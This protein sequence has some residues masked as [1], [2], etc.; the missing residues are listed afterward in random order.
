MEVASR[1]HKLSSSCS[2]THSH[3]VS[4]FHIGWIHC[5]STF[6]RAQCDFFPPALTVTPSRERQREVAATGLTAAGSRKRLPVD[7]SFSIQLVLKSMCACL[8]L[9]CKC[10]CVR[11]TGAQWADA[12]RR[13]K[14]FLCAIFI[15]TGPGND[16]FFTF[17]L[18][19]SHKGQGGDVAATYALNDVF[20]SSNSALSWKFFFLFD[21]SSRQRKCT[22]ERLKR[23]V[24]RVYQLI[25][26]SGDKQL[27]GNVSKWS[28]SF[29]VKRLWRA[30]LCI[31]LN[32]TPLHCVSENVRRGVALKRW[33][34]VIFRSDH[35]RKIILNFLKSSLYMYWQSLP[36]SE[37]ISPVMT[38][39][40][41]FGKI[42]EVG[43]LGQ[44]ANHKAA[45]R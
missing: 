22:A 42:S 21:D 32:L 18:V 6:P 37:D 33:F 34:T 27:T 16:I 31:N 28:E 38:G 8:C 39:N 23:T 44:S 26:T 5:L 19:L 4:S 29:E 13:G 1:S 9:Y 17:T 3:V 15:S 10:K 12:E 40:L 36:K 14:V 25:S 11:G 2:I 7:C 20:R 30:W 43:Y 41:K 35:R 24:K 45:P